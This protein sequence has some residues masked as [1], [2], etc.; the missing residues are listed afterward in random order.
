MRWSGTQIN[1][2]ISWQ[3][4]FNL[5]MD[6][7]HSSLWSKERSFGN[8]P[9]KDVGI[10]GH[11]QA[12]FTAPT[13][14]SEK[15]C[16]TKDQYLSY[17]FLMHPVRVFRWWDTRLGRNW[18]FSSNLRPGLKWPMVQYVQTFPLPRNWYSKK[19]EQRSSSQKKKKFDG[20][21]SP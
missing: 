16:Q 10:Y 15:A 4:V 2:L 5:L 6:S 1:T 7:S 19:L 17:R 14:Q 21:R 8:W 11:F 3:P 18:L 13:R 20:C 12:K 9:M